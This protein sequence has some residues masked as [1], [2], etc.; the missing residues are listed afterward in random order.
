MKANFLVI[1]ISVLVL[2][3]CNFNTVETQLIYKD[4]GVIGLDSFVIKDTVSSIAIENETI[5]SSKRKKNEMSGDCH[6]FI[7]KYKRWIKK[8]VEVMEEY[9]NNP[10]NPDA[11][12]KYQQLVDQGKNL[13]EP[14]ETCSGIKEF[15]D[16]L[17]SI[18]EEASKA[19]KYVIK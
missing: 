19:L 10:D 17:L 14:N 18:T 16:S 1:I 8:Y 4:S 15:Q 2:F 9:K 13:G 5:K 11:V 6:D 3:S 12:A 7:V